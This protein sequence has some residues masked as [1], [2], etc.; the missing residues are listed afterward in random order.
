MRMDRQEEFDIFQ[1]V[2]DLVIRKRPRTPVGK[3]MGFGQLR[4]V[5][6][7][8]QIRVGDLGAIPDHGGGDLSIEKWFRDL[9]GMYG[10]KVEILPPGVDDFFNLGITDEFPENIERSTG[11]YGRKVDDGC[12]GGGGDLDQLEPWNKGIF[13]DEL[14]I[15]SQSL[16]L[17]QCVAEGFKRALVRHIRRK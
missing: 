2:R 8:D 12:G 6:S 7:L 17:S 10:K 5:E 14:R 3:G 4:T 11:L 13:S 16:T 15:Q 9:P 1:G